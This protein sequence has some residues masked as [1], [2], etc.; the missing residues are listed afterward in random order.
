MFAG[1]PGLFISV[2]IFSRIEK[3]QISETGNDLVPAL[4]PWYPSTCLV[5]DL[6]T[7]FMTNRRVSGGGFCAVNARAAGREDATN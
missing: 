6:A 2:L 7:T 5:C 3:D 4:V 1:Q